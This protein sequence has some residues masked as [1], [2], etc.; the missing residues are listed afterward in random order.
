MVG[1]RFATRHYRE[2]IAQ[3]LRSSVFDAVVFHQ[4]GMRWAVPY[5]LRFG[6]NRPT[7]LTDQIAR[8]FIGDQKFCSGKMPV[9]PA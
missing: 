6:R 5:V 8:N 2:A 9:S 4:H 3:E 1:A 7:L